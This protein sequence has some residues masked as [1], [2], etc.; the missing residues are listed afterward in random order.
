MQFYRGET[1]EHLHP[2]KKLRHHETPKGA[3]KLK[4]KDANL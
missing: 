4:Q 3:L 1:G 2:F